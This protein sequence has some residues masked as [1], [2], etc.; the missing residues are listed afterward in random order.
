VDGFLLGLLEGLSDRFGKASWM[1]FYTVCQMV[2]ELA[3]WL[4][5]GLTVG[6]K[7]GI[8]GFH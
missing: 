4:R 6:L 7:V 5:I 3:G 1:A 2:L 8:I